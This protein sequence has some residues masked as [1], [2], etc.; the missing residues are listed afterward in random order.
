MDSGVQAIVI[1]AGIGGLATAV[2]LR[3]QGYE[4]KVYEA[5]AYPGGKL[6]QFDLQGYRFDAGPSLFTLPEEVDA[7]FELTGKNPRDYYSYETLDPITRYFFPDGTRLDAFADPARFAEE[8]EKKTGESQD[9]ILSLLSKSRELY[10]ITHHVFLER[11][12]HKLDTYLRKETLQSILQ[13]HKLDAFRSMNRANTQFFQDPRVVQLFNRYATYNGSNPYEAPATL[14]IIPHLEFNKGAYFPVGGIYQITDSVYRLAQ[15]IGIEFYF[16]TPVDRVVVENGQAVGIAVGGQIHHAEVVVSNVD[17]V[18]TYRKLLRDQEAPEQTLNQPRSSSALIFY[19]GMKKEFPELDVHNIFFTEDYQA[20]FAHIWEKKNLYHDPTVYIH[21]SSKKHAADAPA[22]GENW[23]TM[24]NVP[25][26]AGQDWDQMI[27][28]ARISIL[29]KVSKMLGKE[30]QPYI[31]VE[32]IL[33]PR[34][35]QSRTGSFLGALYGNSSN[36]RFAAFLR[37]PNFSRKIKNL[38]FCGGSVHPGGGIPLCLLSA[39][40]VGDLVNQQHPVQA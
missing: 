8:V 36:N 18:P 10:D 24:I 3:S 25:H 26:D 19:W 38:Y 16:G 7:L 12:L 27:E 21:I 6:S 30:I 9:R 34:T 20:E 29:K 40:I 23:F 13:L 22:G 5:N 31:E 17:I 1:G 39:R 37:H 4:V 32:H 2:R 28:T 33:E 14:N 15:D 35:I 11:S